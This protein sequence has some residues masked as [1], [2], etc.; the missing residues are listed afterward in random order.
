M[1]GGANVGLLE[2]RGEQMALE[3][4]DA[5]ERHAEAPGEGLAVHDADQKRTDQPRARR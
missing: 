1:K 3:V 2:G 4:M 5:D